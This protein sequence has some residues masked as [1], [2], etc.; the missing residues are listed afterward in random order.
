V[1]QPDN[2]HVHSHEPDIRMVWRPRPSR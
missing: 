1:L 2:H